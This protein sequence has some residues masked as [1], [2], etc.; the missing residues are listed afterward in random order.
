MKAPITERA[1][2]ARIDRHL[3]KEGERLR[4][5]R[6]GTRVG[7]ELGSFYI[8]SQNTNTITANNC[9]LVTLARELDLLADWEE[10]EK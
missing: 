6:Q 8:V 2:V 1:L 3:A 4:R 5:G 9:D 7:A 10:L